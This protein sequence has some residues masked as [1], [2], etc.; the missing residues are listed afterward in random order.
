VFAVWAA[1]RSGSAWLAFWSFFLVQAF[2][3]LI[4]VSLSERAKQHASETDDAFSRAQRAA[5]AA[6]RRLSTAR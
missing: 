3:A 2:H 4:P 5:E 6:I 1:N